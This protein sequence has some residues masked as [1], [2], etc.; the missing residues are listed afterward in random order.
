MSWYK[1]RDGTI[2]VGEDS[3]DLVRTNIVFQMG[4]VRRHDGKLVLLDPDLKWM[5][6][7]KKRRP[8][9]RKKDV[10]SDYMKLMAPVGKLLAQER[11]PGCVMDNK[12]CKFWNSRFLTCCL[13]KRRR[14]KMHLPCTETYDPFEKRNRA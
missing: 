10:R 7:K 11:S 13:S 9:H 5:C 14:L 1:E 6:G 2:V 12:K 8:Y 3:E 4:T